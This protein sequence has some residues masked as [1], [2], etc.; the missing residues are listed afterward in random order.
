MPTQRAVEPEKD[1]TPVPASNVH[2]AMSAKDAFALALA[3]LDLEA[4][5]EAE[6]LYAGDDLVELE[7]IAAGTHP[8]QRALDEHKLDDTKRQAADALVQIR[9]KLGT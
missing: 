4:S 3:E 1:P 2:P 9:A 6:K 8:K 7:A 5:R